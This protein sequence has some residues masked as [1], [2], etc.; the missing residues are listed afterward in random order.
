MAGTGESRRRTETSVNRILPYLDPE[1]SPNKKY[2]CP[3]C[4]DPASTSAGPCRPC[5][6]AVVLCAMER[7]EEMIG[8]GD[9]RNA[10][11]LLETSRDVLMRNASAEVN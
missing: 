9:L 4:G 6:V 11:A 7:A 2:D 3:M 10:A 1:S 5:A 8:E